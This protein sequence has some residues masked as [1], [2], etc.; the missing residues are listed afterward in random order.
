[1]YEIERYMLGQRVGTAVV[2]EEAA[3]R[4]DRLRE[5]R[6]ASSM[7]IYGE[8]QYRCD[9]CGDRGHA[10]AASG[11]AARARGSGSVEC[12]RAA[13]AACRCRR[14][15]RSRS[16]PAPS[17]RSTSATR[18][19][20]FWRGGRAYGVPATALRFFNVYGPRQSLSNPYT[21]CRRDLRRRLL[22]GQRAGGVRG[23]APDPRLHPRRRTSPQRSSRPP[24]RAARTVP[25]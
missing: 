2:L 20:C 7:S 18:R 19:R 21:G 13:R 25:R 23:R 8:G 16:R 3:A 15:R 5:G 4:R 17:T 12:P 1:M 10:G 9:G 22:N 24:S 6:V 11:R 14:R